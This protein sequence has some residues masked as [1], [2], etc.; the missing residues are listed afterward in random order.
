MTETTIDLNVLT[1]EPAEE[2]HA[3]ASEFLSSH[4]LID[5]MRCPWLHYKKTAGLIEEKDSTAYLVGRAAHVRILEGRDRYETD[6]A[7]GG[8]ITSPPGSPTVRTRRHSANGRRRSAAW[9]P[10][11]Q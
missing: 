8:P 7:I 9:H 11:S 10:V 3:K 2:Y 4:Q 1:V 5:F 6:F